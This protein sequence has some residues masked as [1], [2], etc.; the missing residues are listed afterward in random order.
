ME[1]GATV[2]VPNGAPLCAVCP[3]RD[4]CLAH[5]KGRETELPVKAAKK[6]RRIEQRTVLVIRDSAR[7]AIR[8]RPKRGL[9][10]GLYELPN[11]SG[12]LDQEEVLQLVKEHGLSP[13]R[14]RK[15]ADARHIFSH[16]EWQME[17]YLVLI[18]DQ[19]KDH[20]DDFLLIEP[21]RTEQDYPVP[22]A[23]AAYMDSLSVK[24]GQNKFD[25]NISYGKD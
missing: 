23:F 6:G 16:V 7:A 2:C 10:A 1:L 12:H 19:E 21:A 20:A 3:V 9:L 25:V 8:R 5:E 14:I 4:L 17:G 22:A 11:Y 13:I 15:L 18:E 24:L